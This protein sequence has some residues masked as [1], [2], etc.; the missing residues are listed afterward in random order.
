MSNVIKK[1]SINKSTLG[2][3]KNTAMI[4]NNFS[5]EKTKK[6]NEKNLNIS[7]LEIKTKELRLTLDNINL[8][9]EKERNILIQEK[10]QLDSDLT[11][12]VLEI[13]T[14]SSQNK[15]LN[16]K[17]N[18]LKLNLDNKI[19]KGKEFVTKMEKLK[20]DEVILNKE[21]LIKEKEI[22][23]IKRTKA[24]EIKNYNFLKNKNINNAEEILLN[25][26]QNLEENKKKLEEENINLRKKIIEHKMCPKSK[27]DL[28]SRLSVITNSYH[29][30]IKNL[31]LLKSNP[32]I[33]KEKRERNEVKNN[34]YPNQR[35]IS[36]G[37]KI[38]KT[39]LRKVKQ[40]NSKMIILKNNTKKHITNTVNNILR[41]YIKNAGEIK[42]MNNYNYQMKKYSLFTENEQVEIPKIIPKKYFSEFERRFEAIDYIRYKTIKDLKN[43]Q[44]IKEKMINSVNINLNYGELKM[45]EQKLLLADIHTKLVKK[46]EKINKLKYEIK[47]MKKEYDKLNKEL[48]SKNKINQNLKKEFYENEKDNKKEQI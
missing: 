48:I 2:T 44:N 39:V 9:I 42:N 4:N 20:K 15:N 18:K 14:L 45:K 3:G 46:R 5:I 34:V 10:S 40:K 21:I 23:L 7:E 26:L 1:K 36:Y 32:N 43:N 12:M 41:N 24:N 38:S 25:K 30:E 47:E 31:N 28:L 29:F 33:T 16:I 6:K 35:S 11:K 8:E 22:D 17:L 19:K 37:K 13:N 27:S